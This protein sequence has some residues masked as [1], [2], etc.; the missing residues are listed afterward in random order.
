MTAGLSV[1]VEILKLARQ[2][3]CRPQ[4]L[5]YLEQLDPQDIRDL[6]EQVTGVLFD[7]DRQMLQRVAAATKLLPSK[8]TA[9]IG[10]SMFSPLLCARVTGLLDPHRAVDIA[11]RLST[12]FLAD[13]APYLDPR[14]ASRVIAEL[15]AEQVAEIA[16]ELV[17][18]EQY[19]T[20]GDVV[21]HLSKAATLAALAAIDD[22][23]LLRTAYV[24][25]SKGSLGS[26][27]ALIPAKRLTAIIRTAS[28]ADLWPEALDVIGHVSEHQRG[29]LADIAAAQDDELLEGLVRV[30]LDDG[31]WPVL[32]PVTRAM[33]PASRE[34]FVGL[35]SVQ[36]EKVLA[37][38][39]DAAA[40]EALWADLLVFLPLLP[41]AARRLVAVIAADLKAEYAAIIDAAHE[42]ELWPALIAFAAE[43]DETTQRRIAELIAAS[44][45]AILAGLLAAVE[46]EELE[47]EALTVF[48]R[49][50]ATKQARFAKRIVALA[51]IAALT[52]LAMAAEAAG[53]DTLHD[54]VK[55]GPGRRKSATKASS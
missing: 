27:V 37:A 30:A 24:V 19:I 51:S 34:R 45:Q 11:A 16:E 23:A 15:P 54:A 50:S 9:T 49:L 29:E 40:Q 20:M 35:P 18:R 42:E 4:A 5:D 52:A 12:S 13:V 2:V 3:G 31:L 21:G 14:R 48:A 36:T 33:S 17:R 46:A 38:I 41:V 6:R 39:V 22:E 32:L 26:L 43:L 25:E 28:E 8:L 44:D 55:P 1:D 47:R 53:L 7:A 10:E